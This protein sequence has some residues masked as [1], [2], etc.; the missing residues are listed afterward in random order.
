MRDPVRVFISHS[1]DDAA[2]AAA[3]EQGL[4]QTAGIQVLIDRSGLEPGRGWRRDLHEWM[5]RCG[6]AV[7]LLTP[8]VLER[9]KWVLK[10]AI[11]LG[12]RF[13]L[14]ADFRLLFALAPGVE[15]QDFLDKGFG[16]A[17]FGEPQLLKTPAALADVPALVA[18]V[19]S[20]LPAEQPRTPFDDLA[21]LLSRTMQVADPLGATYPVL[22]R[23]LGLLTPATYG[24]DK[25]AQLAD[26]VARAIVRGRDDLLALDKL[27]EV[28][29]PWDKEPRLKVLQM[30]RPYWVDAQ[31]AAMLL[32][33]ARQPAEAGGPGAVVI[34]GDAVA[35]F[36]AE[37]YVR[38]AYNTDLGAFRMAAAV[39]LEGGDLQGEIRRE[40]CQHAR[41]ENWVLRSTK[42]DDI[43]VQKL[44]G[45]PFLIV[46][47]LTELPDPAT[48]VALRNEFPR[49]VFIAPRPQGVPDDAQIGALELLP[50]PPSGREAI[51]F[52][53][54]Q[55]AMSAI[56]N[57]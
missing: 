11:V 24:P 39:S 49:A 9:P 22:A 55:R 1:S 53:G 30:L 5:A 52:Q 23:Q 13:D 10:E 27:V 15:H 12:W 48:I 56:G 26:E 54:Y 17:Q 37:T 40:L 4:A 18:E 6:A 45:V 51:E 14:E 28:L 19:A 16:L 20:V 25:R 57:L 34:A 31:A 33:R 36:T 38:R 3:V 41:A 32:R 46:V 44:R 50:R 29:A 7:V 8:A 47:P 42:S 35:E 21:D 43:V 2:L